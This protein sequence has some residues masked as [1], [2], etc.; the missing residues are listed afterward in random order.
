MSEIEKNV[1]TTSSI[2]RAAKT[3]NNLPINATVQGMKTVALLERQILEAEREQKESQANPVIEEVPV[4]TGAEIRKA[5][6]EGEY[7]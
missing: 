2:S 4:P 5:R 1:I 7:R 3:V 6:E